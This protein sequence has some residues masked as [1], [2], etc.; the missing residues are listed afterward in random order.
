MNGQPVGPDAT[1][2]TNFIGTLVRKHVPPPELDWRDVDVQKKLLVW[3]TLKA[4]HE[5]DSTA[6]SF[7]IN[8]SHT[9]WKDWK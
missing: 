3:E 2:F 5:L 4:F 6:L 8:S 9:K 7:V 1:E